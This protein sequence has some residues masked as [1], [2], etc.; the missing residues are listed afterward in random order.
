M[1]YEIL[2]SGIYSKGDLQSEWLNLE[3]YNPA[4]IGMLRALRFGLHTNLIVTDIFR[5]DPKSTHHYWRAVDLRI[6]NSERKVDS[7]FSGQH[8]DDLHRALAD[9]ATMFYYDPDH[10]VYRVHGQGL[11]RHAHLQTK[12]TGPWTQTQ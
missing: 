8:L 10:N 12:G 3:A 9:L 2:D 4:L 5:D 6:F 1:I 11:N 7:R